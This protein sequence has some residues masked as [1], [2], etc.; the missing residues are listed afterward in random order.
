MYQ[1]WEQLR[2]WFI[3]GVLLVISLLVMLGQNDGLVKGMRAVALDVT[4]HVEA[5]F[6]W[7]GNFLRAVEENEA[8]RQENI[9]LSSEVARAREAMIEN[10]R[11]RTQLDMRDTTALDLVPAEIIQRDVTGQQN[12]LTINIG[13]D[14]GVVEGMGVVAVQGVIGR[15]VLVSSRFSRVMPYLNTDMRIPA[16][17]HPSLATGVIRWPGLDPE[18]LVMDYVVRTAEVEEG[19]RVVSGAESTVFPS[20]Y[21]IGHIDSIQQ[22]PGRNHLLVNVRPAA[23]LHITQHVFVVRH[24]PDPD[25]LFLREQPFR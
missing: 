21:L 7:V 6:A 8:L 20:G 9:A 15:V 17:I 4:S 11:L 1:I 3:L 12:L 10:E 19:D 5:R 25:L 14:H 24:E 2:D 22:Q 23:N 13:S 16:K 18:M